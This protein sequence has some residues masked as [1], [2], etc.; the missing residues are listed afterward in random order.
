MNNAAFSTTH[1]VQF[2]SVRG[3][4]IKFE[5]QMAG[6]GSP[7]VK[8]L[9]LKNYKF[10]FNYPSSVYGV[11]NKSLILNIIDTN[12]E[13]LETLDL[14]VEFP[15]RVR[16]RIDGVIVGI[17]YPEIKRLKEELY[18]LGNRE[19]LTISMREIHNIYK[20][21]SFNRTE[22][23]AD[24]LGYKDIP[25]TAVSSNLVTDRYIRFDRFLEKQILKM[26]NTSVIDYFD[27]YDAFQSRFTDKTIFNGIFFDY[28]Y[29]INTDE[30]PQGTVSIT[31]GS[32]TLVGV[33]TQFTDDFSQGDVIYSRDN[34]KFI[35]VVRSV[36]ND[37]NLIFY[38]F[39]EE[40]FS[41]TTVFKGVFGASFVNFGQIITEMA[42]TFFCKIGFSLQTGRFSVYSLTNGLKPFNRNEVSGDVTTSNFKVR[43]V[44]QST[45]QQLQKIEPSNILRNIEPSTIKLD[46]AFVATARTADDTIF[47][48]SLGLGNFLPIF[49]DAGILTNFEK[50]SILQNEV[51]ETLTFKRNPLLNG[52]PN[53]NMVGAIGDGANIFDI[54]FLAVDKNITPNATSANLAERAI[55]NRLVKQLAI[56][57]F[58]NRDRLNVK[59]NFL[60]DPLKNYLIDI[61][62]QEKIMTPIRG[63]WDLQRETTVVSE[64]QELFDEADVE[65]V[66]NN[67]WQFNLKRR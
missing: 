28:L 31:T 17:F 46:G 24:L 55:T 54:A 50:P 48:I 26:H 2:N 8:K 1:E 4:I 51:Q 49:F 56:W 64:F 47:E 11:L 43:N 32:K 18:S 41:A 40:N 39:P 14:T 45:N 12:R 10:S 38:D 9:N 66:D 62:G 58:K 16:I 29:N 15:L 20:T 25:Q 42:K 63:E 61:N 19:E 33:G 37:T 21:I 13:I 6:K 27:N 44:V 7:T 5:L 60:L 30:I 35:G 57:R 34:G 67:V 3:K 52:K 36:T 59:V 23:Q 65:D 22:I 53:T